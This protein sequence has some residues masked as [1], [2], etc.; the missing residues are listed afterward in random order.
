[1]ILIEE[2]SRDWKRD[3]EWRIAP[4]GLAWI[5]EGHRII[6]GNHARIGNHASIGNHTR[7]GDGASIGDRKST[8]LNSS[9]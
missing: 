2:I 8:R 5:A 1:M 3:G 7:I 6:V 4:A 9:H